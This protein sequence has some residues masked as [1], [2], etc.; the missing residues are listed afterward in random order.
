MDL[1]N[2]IREI[3]GEEEVVVETPVEETKANE[4]MHTT[5]TN[6]GKE[7]IPTNVVVDPLLD[8]VPEYSQLLW[9]LPWN[10]GNNM[11]ISAK[12]P[13]IGEVDLF[14]GNTEWTTWAG[15]TTPANNGPHTGEVVITQGQF[16]TTVSISKRELN[17]APERLEAIVRERI[18]RAAARTIDAVLIN[19]DTDSSA[20][21]NGTFDSTAYYAQVDNGIRKV[22]LTNTS[23]VGTITASA[24]LGIKS[25]IDAG[26]QGSL[27]DLLF[28]EDGESYNKSLGLAE[29]ITA[30]KFGPQATIHAGVLAKIF[31]ID[32][33]VAR[34]MPKTGTDGKVSTTTSNNT[35]GTIAC[36]YKPAVQ[37]GFGQPLEIEVE[38]VAGK[39][40]NLVATFEFGFAIAD[41]KAN[42]W[43]TVALWINATL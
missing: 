8:L 26:L 27:S 43:R 29:V 24:Y 21:I 36:I 30:D 18:N 37:Y 35:K 20:N 3:K 33:V 7:L 12:V 17:Y 34:D 28:I 31:G 42:L 41:G 32:V 40:I 39:G 14:K 22:W 11:P 9:M 16:I 10:H 15:S 6:F 2:L 4:V 23:S 5:N 1:K 13:V 38:K 25:K 19:G